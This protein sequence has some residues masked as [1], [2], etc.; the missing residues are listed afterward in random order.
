MENKLNNKQKFW[1]SFTAIL[2]IGLWGISFELKNAW[3]N[4]PTH[5]YTNHFISGDEY[6]EGSLESLSKITRD[7]SN[8]EINRKDIS[9][10]EKI[11]CTAK[12][13]YWNGTDYQE[14]TELR[15]SNDCYAIE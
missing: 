6:V 13:L 4:T 1:L 5:F 15:L 10:G 8:V 14:D 11:N 7:I 2:M 3:I 12:V 9:Y